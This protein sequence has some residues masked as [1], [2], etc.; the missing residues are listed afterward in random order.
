MNSVDG[1]RYC[2]ALATLVRTVD[3][4]LSQYR[5]EMLASGTVAD[6]SKWIRLNRPELKDAVFDVPKVS[7]WAT[8]ALKL[9]KPPLVT[10]NIS[11]EQ[12]VGD[13]LVKESDAASNSS[14]ECVDNVA[15]CHSTNGAELVVSEN[16]DASAQESEGMADSEEQV[17][18]TDSITMLD[19]MIDNMADVSGDGLMDVFDDAE[20]N[21]GTEEYDIPVVKSDP[22]DAEAQNGVHSTLQTQTPQ[23]WQKS[24]YLF[25]NALIRYKGIDGLND[26][27]QSKHVSLVEQLSTEELIA[28]SEQ[29][30]TLRDHNELTD[31]QVEMLDSLCRRKLWS[32][33]HARSASRHAR[34]RS[35]APATPS[36]QSRSPFTPAVVSQHSRPATPTGSN[37]APSAGPTSGPLRELDRPSTPTPSPQQLAIKRAANRKQVAKV[38]A[39]MAKNKRRTAGERKQ[40]DDFLRHYALLL[41][42]EVSHNT[43]MPPADYTTK[44]AQGKVVQLGM[45]VNCQLASL[46]EYETEYPYWYDALAALAETGKLWVSE[47]PTDAAATAS[48]GPLGSSSSGGGPRPPG[49]TAQDMSRASTDTGDRG[50]HVSRSSTEVNGEETAPRVSGVKRKTTPSPEPNE[51]LSRSPHSLPAPPAREEGAVTIRPVPR[52][53]QEHRNSTETG[54]HLAQEVS[55]RSKH[56]FQERPDNTSAFHKQHTTSAAAPRKSSVEPLPMHAVEALVRAAGSDIPATDKRNQQPALTAATNTTTTTAPATKTSMA[57]LPQPVP[58]PSSYHPPG[59]QVTDLPDEFAAFV[60]ADGDTGKMRFGLGRVRSATEIAAMQKA[61]QHSLNVPDGVVSLSPLIPRDALEPVKTGYMSDKTG[62]KILL[63][64]RDQLL[65]EGLRMY[66]SKI[67]LLSSLLSHCTVSDSLVPDIRPCRYKRG[68]SVEA[69]ST[70]H[71]EAAGGVQGSG[72]YAQGSSVRRFS[73]SKNAAFCVRVCSVW[74]V[75][76]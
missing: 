43:Y 71:G 7:D 2:N 54:F 6:L 15:D 67:L 14:A 27:A 62:D 22:S 9:F 48:T 42:Y 3:V 30:R 65:C 28:W 72:I 17:T 57:Q 74:F 58:V 73:L 76:V 70:V 26:A 52:P 36:P 60:I 56:L 41:E 13:G 39:N 49:A 35:P 69:G 38:R 40:D 19:K 25:Q 32:W 64:P 11:S 4:A 53:N 8:N 37:T 16:H 31:G 68:V 12:V 45:W 59:A 34:E 18:S 44:D 63:L 61:G 21:T 1:D 46:A 66:K 75:H 47:Q 24:Y 20:N 5:A 51:R 50:R 29:Q 33:D 55:L 23:Q 10:T